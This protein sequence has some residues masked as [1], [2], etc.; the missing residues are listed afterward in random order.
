[1]IIE[2]HLRTSCKDAVVIKTV[3]VIIRSFCK[4]ICRTFVSLRQ[5]KVQFTIFEIEEFTT[6]VGRTSNEIVECLVILY[7]IRLTELIVDGF[8]VFISTF[9][10]QHL[11]VHIVSHLFR[12]VRDVIFHNLLL[13]NVFTQFFSS[14][15]LRI[16][17]QGQ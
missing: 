2:F 9:V 3:E 8:A 7:Q 4:V 13:E 15:G 14:I 6:A 11:Q 12:R 17:L 16:L 5:A 10:S 1:M